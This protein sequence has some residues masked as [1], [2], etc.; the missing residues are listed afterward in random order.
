MIRH[1]RTHA[2]KVIGPGAALMDHALFALA[3]LVVHLLLARH[4]A[5]G[6]YAGFAV[7]FSAV[8]G[9]GLLTRALLNEPMLVFGGRRYRRRQRAYVGLVLLM[10]LPLGALGG[11]VLFAAGRA[12]EALGQVNIGLALVGSVLFQYTFSLLI[13]SRRVGYL[14]H[15]PWI[16]T[17]VSGAYLAATVLG[18]ALLHFTDRLSLGSALAVLTLSSCL[19]ALA[20]LLIVRPRWGLIAQR[21]RI[22]CIVR[23]HLRYGR[24]ALGAGFCR[25]VPRE[26][27]VLLL[28][29]LAALV[30]VAGLRAVRNLIAPLLMLSAA[31]SSLL[32]PRLAQ[33]RGQRAFYPTLRR[34]TGLTMLPLLGAGLVLACFPEMILRLAYGDR[35]AGYAD[36]LWLAALIPLAALWQATTGAAL[37]ARERPDVDLGCTLLGAVISLPI[38]LGWSALEPVPRALLGMLIYHAVSAL[39]AMVWLRRA[40]RSV[41]MQDEV[42]PRVATRG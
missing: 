5:V 40:V 14:T 42:H 13:L 3:N 35:F 26:A 23:R 24:W 29:L 4:L 25:Y 6:D 41:Q 27:Y 16:A 19:G 33:L 15:R 30:D 18:F 12:L 32:T 22:V 37:R 31:L 9:L 10:Q 34:A 2:S 1:L 38:G 17:L 11:L 21:R 39:S 7:A 28:P 20:G 8:L 36:S